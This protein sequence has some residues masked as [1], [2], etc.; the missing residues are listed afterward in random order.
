MVFNDYEICS[1]STKWP[2][3]Q[4]RNI[5]TKT[6]STSTYLLGKRLGNDLRRYA[7][8]TENL[9]MIIRRVEIHAPAIFKE[10]YC[11]L[12][13][14]FQTI[15]TPHGIEQGGLLASSQ[16]VFER[17]RVLKARCK[18]RGLFPY[19]NCG[20]EFTIRLWSNDIC[21]R[22]VRIRCTMWGGTVRSRP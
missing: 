19:A 4:A 5:A 7:R 16:D 6:P 11:D 17:L 8:K 3:K 13:I 10:L 2:A 18:I 14:D 15:I 12:H 9:L 1:I 22:P 20:S 21:E